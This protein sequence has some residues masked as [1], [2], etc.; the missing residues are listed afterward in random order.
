M[1]FD[2]PDIVSITIAWT[3]KT[4]GPLNSFIYLSIELTDTFIFV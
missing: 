4:P 3:Y 1:D 2:H